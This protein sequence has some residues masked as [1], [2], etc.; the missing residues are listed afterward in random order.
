VV[1]VRQL[2]EAALVNRHEYK[3]PRLHII[4]TRI[5]EGSNSE[6]DRLIR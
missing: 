4:F 2:I 6:V 5:V 3:P 1:T